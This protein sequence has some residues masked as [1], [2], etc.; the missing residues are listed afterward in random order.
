MAGLVAIQPAIEG[1][2][3]IAGVAALD[4]QP[5]QVQARGRCGSRGDRGRELAARQARALFEALADF[6][7][8]RLAPLEHR[9][10]CALSPACAA[11]T[12]RPTR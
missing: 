12:C 5:R 9:V 4:Q 8:A 6:P 11:S 10:M 2:L 1:L 7:Q 3:R